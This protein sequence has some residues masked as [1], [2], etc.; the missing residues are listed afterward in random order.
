MPDTPPDKRLDGWK[1]I[2]HYFRRDRTTVMRW[3]R[4]RDLPVHRLPGGSVFALE[5]ELECWSTAYEQVQA[6]TASEGESPQPPSADRL[7]APEETPP[8]PP[9]PIQAR[10]W[11]WAWLAAVPVIGSG[12]FLMAQP[13]PSGTATTKSVAGVGSTATPRVAMPADPQAASDYAAARDLWAQRTPASLRQSILLY[14]RVIAREPGFAPA[15]VGLA[16]AWLIFREYGEA[17]ESEAY[18]QAQ[19]AVG[20]ALKLDPDLAGA[21]RAH[22]FI[23]YWWHND[24]LAAKAAFERAL[25]LAPDDGLTH[26]W[27]ANMLA[28]KGDDD[29]AQAA[30]DRARVLLPGTPAI[31]VERACAEWQA[32]RDA[33]AIAALDALKARYPDDAT[34]HNCLA[35]A[36]ISRGDIVG[37]AR[38]YRRAAEL[39]GEVGMIALSDRLDAAIARDPATAHR[40]LIADAR[41]EFAEGARR[42][43]ISPAFFASSMGD[44]D[45]LEQLMREA[46]NLDERWYSLNL[47]RRMAA[48]WRDDA[49][50]MD[51]LTRLDASDSASSTR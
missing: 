38:D 26:F 3:A 36:H 11:H 34:I 2:A 33:E 16:E 10:R 4:E 22:G 1:A 9:P 41:R 30:Y 23:R 47:T 20:V 37:Y 35:W 49:E 46:V 43:R 18:R 17:S 21:H 48:R 25:V 14:R 6:E 44:R 24:G 32:G 40:V 50:I 51:L 5:S 15:H 31:E 19:S 28:D 27:Y 42:T 13:A 39:R 8:V 7:T 45:T 29:G 12:A